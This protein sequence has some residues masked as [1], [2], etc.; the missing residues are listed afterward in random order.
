MNGKIN[1]KRIYPMGLPYGRQTPIG[2]KGP[3]RREK[4]ER[5][6]LTR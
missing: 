6:Y 2:C 5:E 1:K 3:N 4:G